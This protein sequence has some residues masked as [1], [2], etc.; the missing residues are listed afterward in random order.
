MHAETVKSES[1]ETLEQKK[2]KILV[3]TMRYPK[4]P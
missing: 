2:V 4:I 3:K 1:E